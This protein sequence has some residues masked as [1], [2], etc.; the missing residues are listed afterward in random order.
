LND[1]GVEYLIVGG[2]AVIDISTHIDGVAFDTDGE[3]GFKTASLDYPY[4]SFRLSDLI[5]NKQST[6]RSS[7][8]EHAKDLVREV[9]KKGSG[10][11]E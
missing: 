10:P 8:L 2:Y 3:I 6:G 9:K 1:C 5:V 4:T 7:D 11:K